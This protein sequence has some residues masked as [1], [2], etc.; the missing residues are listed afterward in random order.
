MIDSEDL[1]SYF[2]SFVMPPSWTGWF[3]CEKQVPGHIVGLGNLGANVRGP[4]D[5]PNRMDA[6][7]SPLP[8]QRNP[9]AKK[10]ALKAT[11]S[12]CTWIAWMSFGWSPNLC[13]TWCKV[14]S[15]KTT[16]GLKRPAS[17]QGF[18]TTARKGFGQRSETKS[19]WRSCVRTRTRPPPSSARRP[20]PTGANPTG[21]A[22]AW[23]RL[24][25]KPHWREAVRA[26]RSL[27]SRK[28]PTKREP[29]AS[30]MFLGRKGFT[31]TC[32]CP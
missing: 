11:W 20:T 30:E 31:K 2:S 16:K 7:P 19:H 5:S 28:A 32:E 26:R 14:R 23:Q 15:R 13:T 10:T 6:L 21:A 9:E 12:S 17:C 27:P 1:E 3:V 29:V 4:T 8:K 25:T 18:P 24:E 22:T